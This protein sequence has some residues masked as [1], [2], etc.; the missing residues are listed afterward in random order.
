MTTQNLTLLTDF[1]ELTMMQG[2][3]HSKEENTPVVFDIFFRSNPSGGGYSIAA[4]LE[5]VIEYIK[6]LNFSYEDVDYLRS[7]NLFDETFLQYLSGF[8]FSGSIYAIPEGTVIFPREPLLKVIAPVMEAQLVETALLNIINH[9]SLIATK[10]SRVVYAADGDG[11]M[12]FG[13]R[14]AQGPDAGLYGARAAMIG[15][16][17]GTS[18][19]LAGR[20]FDVPVKG[21]HAH[22]WIMSFPDE[23]TAFKTYAK[24][25]PSACCLL[26]DTYDTLKS[27]VPNAIRVFREMREEGIELKNYGIRLDSGDLAYLSKKARKMLDAAGFSDAFISASN[28]LD[29]YL[30]LDLKNQGAAITSWGV[31]TSMITSKDCPAF[32]GVYKLA[33]I[34]NADG[35]F[36]PKIKLSE[37]TEKITNPGNKT[38]HRIYDKE[39][40]KLL[41]DLICFVDEVFDESKDLLLFDPVETW[42][43]TKLKG[44]TYTMRELL[45]PVFLNGNCVYQSPTVM[46]IAAYCRKEKETLWDEVTR[47]FNPHKVYI[48]LSKKL[49][50]VKK[51]LLDQM[52]IQ[53]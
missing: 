2:Y 53:E 4:G 14:R 3:F 47:L 18:N 28:D 41:A 6:N 35:E 24:L 26:V 51:E 12:E 32:G 8:H 34:Q 13:L 19:V 16:C 9:Q 45:K 31:G 39:T 43:K 42:K 36:V 49:Y 27:G 25:Y 20:M 10:A 33:A 11:V 50:D 22:S 1:Y 15:G 21:T 23:Y 30:I 29:E 46:E 5:Q 7:L 52:S 37:N 38:V 48:D 44:G 40:G 17:I